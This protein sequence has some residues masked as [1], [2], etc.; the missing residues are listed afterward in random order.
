M[1]K[2]KAKKTAKKPPRFF[3]HY[4]SEEEEGLR[5]Y[6]TK[7][8]A[9]RFIKGLMDRHH[10]NAGSVLVTVIEGH[11]RDHEAHFGVTEVNIK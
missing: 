7:S 8:L 3:V 2:K 9:E 4:C 5:V 1:S 6:N 11:E 10:R